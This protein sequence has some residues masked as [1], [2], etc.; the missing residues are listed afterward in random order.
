MYNHNLFEIIYLIW[1]LASRTKSY[2]GVL[3]LVQA[4][5]WQM[6]PMRYRQDLIFSLRMI[7]LYIA[8]EQTTLRD[9]NL[10][11]NDLKMNDK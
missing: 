7:Y 3:R 9:D 11:Q 5:W 4:H 8:A 10:F 2:E 1:L 6:D